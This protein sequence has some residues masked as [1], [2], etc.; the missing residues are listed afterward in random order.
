M[1]SNCQDVKIQVTELLRIELADACLH[2][3]IIVSIALSQIALS[4]NSGSVA[5]IAIVFGG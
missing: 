4:V 3:Y 2:S 1:Q 5:P